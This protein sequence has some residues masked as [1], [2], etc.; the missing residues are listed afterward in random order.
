MT[1]RVRYHQRTEL[2]KKTDGKKTNNLITQ[3]RALD[4]NSPYSMVY[5]PRNVSTENP[6]VHQLQLYIT[7]LLFKLFFESS[8]QIHTERVNTRFK[9]NKWK[10]LE[11]DFFRSRENRLEIELTIHFHSNFSLL[12]FILHEREL[13]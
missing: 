4:I 1:T 13:K 8:N 12:L 9:H 5:I 2:D 3:Y 11:G 6:V 7:A 10:T